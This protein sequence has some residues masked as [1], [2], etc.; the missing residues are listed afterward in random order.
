MLPVSLNQTS[1]NKSETEKSNL[2]FFETMLLL[3]WRQ[4]ASL[5]IL[6]WS[7]NT[8]SISNFFKDILKKVRNLWCVKQRNCSEWL[9]NDICI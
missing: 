1:K 8:R 3:L 6:P 2:R 7:E 9:K 5:S 4:L